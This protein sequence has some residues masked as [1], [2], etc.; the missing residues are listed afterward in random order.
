TGKLDEESL[1]RSLRGLAMAVIPI[2]FFLSYQGNLLAVSALIPAGFLIVALIFALMF[3]DVRAIRTGPANALWAL[4]L[5]TYG[6]SLLALLLSLPPIR[7]ESVV[8]TSGL[9]AYYLFL[10]QFNDVLQF[11]WGSIFGRHFI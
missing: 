8:Q 11:L 1:P 5:T 7:S 3:E 9:F 2:Q 4:L 10:T 6:L